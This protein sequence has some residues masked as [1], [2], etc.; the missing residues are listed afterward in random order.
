MEII[1]KIIDIF[2][3]DFT[4]EKNDPIKKSKHSDFFSLLKFSV[5]N[6]LIEKIYSRCWP[7]LVLSLFNYLQGE[8]KDN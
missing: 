1:S 2:I 3:K 7:T 6:G 8:K 4:S 5:E